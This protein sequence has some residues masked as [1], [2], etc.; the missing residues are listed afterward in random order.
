MRNR[1]AVVIL[2]LTLMLAQPL[3]GCFGNDEPA[4]TAPEWTPFD[5]EHGNTTWYHYPG[6][7]NAHNASL[8]W[9]NLTENN[10]PFPAYATYFG[11][12]DTT[13]EPTIGVTAGAIH[14]SSYGGTGSGTMVFTSLDQGLSWTNMGPFNPVF[15]DTGQVPSSNDP[16][17]Y[18]DRWTDRLVKFDMHALTAMFVE[19]SDDDGQTWSIPFTADGYYS[20]QDHQSIASTLDVEGMSSYETIYVFCI[21]TGSSALGPQCSRSM[22]GGHTWDIQRPVTNLSNYPGAKISKS[23][24]FLCLIPRSNN[25]NITGRHSLC[26]FQN[27]FGW[28]LK[29]V[30]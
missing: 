22:D 12:G 20:P 24:V 23:T 10:T 18:A 3:A 19:Y 17:I 1:F 28:M 30:I 13:F 6:G 11:I 2:V 7:I 4:P 26:Q 27:L 25:I 8:G 14:F 15:Q 16:Y 21:N 29:V 9:D 5:F